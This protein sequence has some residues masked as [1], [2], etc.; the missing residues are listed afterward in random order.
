[1][2][3][4]IILPGVAVAGGLVGLWIRWLYLTRGFQAVTGLPVAGSP[5]LWAMILVVAAVVVLPLVLSRG[6]QPVFDRCYTG[7]FATDSL[8]RL[9]AMLAGAVLMVVGGFLCLALWV[10]SPMNF[11]TNR[12]E[13]SLVWAVTGLLF[14]LA[15]AGIFFVTQ[16]MRQGK[17]ILTTWAVMPGFAAC[18][19]VMSNYHQ[20]WAEEPILGHYSVPM[21][22]AVL[23]MIGCLLVAGFAFDKG[24]VPVTQTV[25]VAAAALD[26]MSL[27]DG[28]P[29]AD[30]AIYLAM[31]FY[32]TAMVSSLAVNAA[33]QREQ[34]LCA[35]FCQSCAG[36]APMGTMPPKEKKKKKKGDPDQPAAD[37]PVSP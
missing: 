22:A 12:R 17:P 15:A 13:Y 8:P 18:L 32:L 11:I 1:M 20:T 2:R 36:C 33:A 7:A 10:S 21:L 28:L 24:R 25:C 37:T 14:L 5:F 4:S 23:S 9:A 31:V 34:P 3:K 29:L 35:P 19:W 26:I 30:T 6:K 16:R 27:A